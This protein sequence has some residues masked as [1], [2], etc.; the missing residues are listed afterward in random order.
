MLKIVKPFAGVCLA[1]LMVCQVY[2]SGAADP[3]H[4]T[5]FS[6]TVSYELAYDDLAGPIALIND[7][8]QTPSQSPKSILDFGYL[9]ASPFPK[10]L[11]H[12]E[13]K[14]QNSFSNAQAVNIKFGIREALFPTH[15]FW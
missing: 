12:F 2:F 1:I 10:I 4:F 11:F 15:F 6:N 9:L 8:F 13:Q 3:F 14:I 7:W 5:S